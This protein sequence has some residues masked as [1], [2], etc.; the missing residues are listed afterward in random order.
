MLALERFAAVDFV[1][2]AGLPLAA[3]AGEQEAAD[4]QAEHED[5]QDDDPL[6]GG[7][8]AAS[9]DTPVSWSGLQPS[10]RQSVPETSTAAAPKDDGGVPTPEGNGLSA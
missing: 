2:V 8:V 4:Q 1:V 5:Q 6:V 10:R 3:A 7:E 9:V